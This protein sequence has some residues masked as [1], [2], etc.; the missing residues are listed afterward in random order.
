[1]NKYRN[2]SSK[3][4][5]VS[6]IAKENGSISTLMENKFANIF[7]YNLFRVKKNSSVELNISVFPYLSR[8]LLTGS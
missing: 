1:M 2:I 4:V 8:V 3:M 5:E 6:R 7:F